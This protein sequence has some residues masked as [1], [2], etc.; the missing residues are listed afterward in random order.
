MV[1]ESDGRG[2]LKEGVGDVHLVGAGL[3]DACAIGEAEAQLWGG[4]GAERAADERKGVFCAREV[5]VHLVHRARFRR[6][7]RGFLFGMGSVLA[8]FGGL[9]PF[10]FLQDLD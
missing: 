10:L 5:G 7:S 1:E 4:A 8:P 6:C 9:R 3:E 2:G